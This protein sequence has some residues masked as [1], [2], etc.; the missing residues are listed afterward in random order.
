M[1]TLLLEQERLDS[2]YYLEG[3]D[4]TQATAYLE[5]DTEVRVQ[6]QLQQL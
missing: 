5:S 1:Q 3:L 6:L 4:Q 2:H